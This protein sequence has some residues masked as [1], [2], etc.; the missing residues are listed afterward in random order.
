MT[1]FTDS[2]LEELRRLNRLRA[3]AGGPE[4]RD[5]EARFDERFGV[6]FRLAVYGSLAPGL[7]NHD[8]VAEIPGE[9]S[10]GF[11][12]T[13]DLEPLG[14]G[15]HL[16]FPALRWRPDGPEV[17]VQLFVSSSLGDHWTRL[18]RFE[19]SDYRRILVPLLKGGEV[20]AVAN[21]YEA[22]PRRES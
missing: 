4:L 20:G 7:S 6:D 19:G 12:V 11:V 9:W 8:Q 17:E 22:V 5:L 2:D 14:W 21:L 3:G 15:V 10:P 13:G 16:G 1:Q 18:D